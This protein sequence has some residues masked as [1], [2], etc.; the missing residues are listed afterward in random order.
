MDEKI[1][2]A[3]VDDHEMFRSGVKMILSEEKDLEVVIEATNGESY[4]KQLE[5]MRPDI[6]LLDI[7]MP[8]LDGFETAKRAIKKHP[9]IQIIVLSMHSQVDY[10]Y[11][12]IDIGVKGFVIKNSGIDELLNAIH[13]VKA[14]KSYFAQD[15]LQNIVETMGKN[16][17]TPK[18]G[19]TQKEINVLQL[20]CNGLTNHEI[21]DQL[22]LSIKT[23]EKYRSNL[24][25]KTDT[26]NS[27]HLVKFA[28]EN[29]LIEL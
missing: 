3:L 22:F 24:L 13:K 23:I 29:K 25:H 18:A 17:E 19:L 6:T 26:R 2:L 15:L 5:V 7:S 10:Y 28:I 14:G 8:G 11:K 27:A 12:M 21:A 9:G 16:K 20:I 4:L 1:K